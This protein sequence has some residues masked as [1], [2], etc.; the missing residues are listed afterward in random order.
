MRSS[1]PWSHRRL[2]TPTATFPAIINSEED[3]SDS[4]ALRF[5]DNVPMVDVVDQVGKLRSESFLLPM[6]DANQE[7]NKHVRILRKKLQQIEILEAKQSKGHVL[8]DQ[9]M[10]KLHTKPTLESSLAELGIPR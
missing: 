2:P 5:R 9:Q 3:F 4:E 6:N 1:E 10:A 7:L 8:D